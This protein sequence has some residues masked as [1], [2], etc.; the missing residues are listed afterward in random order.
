MLSVFFLGGYLRADATPVP[1]PEIYLQKMLRFY[2]KQDITN[3]KDIVRQSVLYTYEAASMLRLESQVDTLL[4]MWHR[5]S[6]YD[7]SATDPGGESVGICQTQPKD[8]TRWRKFWLERGVT[9]G[10]FTDVKTQIFFGVSAFN[11]K[12]KHSKGNVK[13]AVRRYN[14]AGEMARLYA[15]R[16]LWSRR[17][18]FG[19]GY[20]HKK[21]ERLTPFN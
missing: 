19:H 17:L 5:E 8:S 15:R 20:N 16:V 7:P 12:L 6:T 21:G 2:A 1:T 13:E 4:S 3:N 14:G 18:I 10:P 9:L 11:E